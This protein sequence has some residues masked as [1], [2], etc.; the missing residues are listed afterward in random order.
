[1][2]VRVSE[3]RPGLSTYSSSPLDG[4]VFGPA[5]LAGRG[6]VSETLGACHVD[7]TMY[8]V[9]KHSVL[10]V[11]CCYLPLVPACTGRAVGGHRSTVSALGC[12]PPRCWLRGGLD[13]CHFEYASLSL[14]LA[15]LQ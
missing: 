2:R 10:A 9:Y 13:L 12:N 15:R 8:E 4:T 1:M 14:N 11:R 7:G 5:S 3:Q 6:T